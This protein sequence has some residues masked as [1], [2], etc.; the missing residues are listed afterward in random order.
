[1]N[2]EL[3]KDVTGV[4]LDVVQS[5]VEDQDLPV[6]GSAWALLG[7]LLALGFSE[8]FVDKFESSDIEFVDGDKI[9]S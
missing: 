1:V 5:W 9:D 6:P 7:D 4:A 2:E 8:A 3:L